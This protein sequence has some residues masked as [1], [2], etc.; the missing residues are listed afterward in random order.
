ML[1][2]QKEYSLIIR[3]QWASEMNVWYSFQSNWLCNGLINF[4]T[5]LL[6]L[7]E[8][9]LSSEIPSLILLW[10]QFLLCPRTDHD[11]SGD[12]VVRDGVSSLTL[13]LFTLSAR[14]NMLLLT[15]REGLLSSELPS[16]VLHSDQ[17]LLC[18][19]ADHDWSGDQVVRDE[20]SSLTLSL[21]TV[22]GR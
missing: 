6:P 11:W 4:P 20:V 8:G 19:R 2:T 21:F 15:L 17:F 14:W 7:R 1:S 22:S 5:L 16:L 3:E 10:D 12:Q 18:P 13:S 9:L